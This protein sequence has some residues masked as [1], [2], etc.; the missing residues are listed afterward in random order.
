MKFVVALLGL[1]AFFVACNGSKKE[2]SQS[3]Q[4]ALMADSAVISPKKDSLSL[5]LLDLKANPSLPESQTVTVSD[6]PVFH[7]AKSY[8]AIPLKTILAQF[9]PA[10]KTLD[11][12]QAQIIFECEDGY[13]PSMSLEKVLSKK[14]F[15]AISDEEAP[16]GQEWINPKKDGHEIKIAP[17]YVV[18]TDVSSEDVTY[19]WPYNLVKISLSAASKELAVLFPKDDDTQVKGFELFKVNCLTCHSLNKVGGKMGP[20]LNYPKSVTEYWQVAH[21]KSFV[22]APSSYRNDCKMP[23]ITHLTE[24]ELDEIVGYLQYMTKHKL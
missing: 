9:L 22:K 24:K 18:Y 15:L 20:E 16:Q 8:K 13:N 4:T 3:N 14:A 1:S 23:A 21:I 10:Y 2:E 11:I 17:F 7:K 6:D 5:Y 12:K 19:K